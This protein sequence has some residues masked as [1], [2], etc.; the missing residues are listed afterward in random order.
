VEEL[1]KQIAT[2]LNEKVNLPF[3]SEKTEQALFETIVG[4]V[5]EVIDATV[6]KKVTG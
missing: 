4:V 6:L 2:K 3:L 5:F 1:K